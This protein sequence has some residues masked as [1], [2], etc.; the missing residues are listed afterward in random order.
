MSIINTFPTTIANGQ[1]EDATVVMSLFAW[2][3]S[4][5][6][7][8]ACP[9]TSGSAV[10]KGNGAGG[11]VAATAGTDYSAGTQA[12]ATGI[13]KSTTGTGAL[14]IAVA[15]DFPTL[16]QNTSGN[17]A[18]ATTS[19]ACSGNAATATFATSAGSAP[20]AGGTSAACSGNSATATALSTASGSAPSYGARLWGLFSTGGI[21]A[22]GNLASVNH[23]GTGL[24]TLTFTTAMPD[25]NYAALFTAQRVSG[26]SSGM[27]V[28]SE[29]IARTTSSI[30][31]ICT[32]QAGAFVD[33]PLISVSIFR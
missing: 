31:I 22:G 1:V 21:F 32:N 5:T 23:T 26:N 18:T 30:S 29:L 14:T 20:A 15:G 10:L 6:N 12:L 16:N 17:A 8:N 27:I 24:F 9:A 33:P 19:A 2:I 13:V 28:E 4:Q 3:Q 11:T 7:G 25:T